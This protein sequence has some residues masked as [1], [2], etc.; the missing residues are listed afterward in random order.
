MLV[1]VCE[2]FRQLPN[3]AAARPRAWFGLFL[4]IATHSVAIITQGELR[5]FRL[6][7]LIMVL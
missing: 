6:F 2:I 3:P 4:G 7:S 5:S 1:L